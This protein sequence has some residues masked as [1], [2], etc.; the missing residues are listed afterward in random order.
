MGFVIGLLLGTGLTFAAMYLHA[1]P[2]KRA[3]LMALFKKKP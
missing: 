3:E 2:E 1:H